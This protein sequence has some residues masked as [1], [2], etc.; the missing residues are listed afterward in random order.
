MLP[1]VTKAIT[2]HSEDEGA[3]VRV[4]F[5]FDTYTTLLAF[6]LVEE[7]QGVMSPS[8]A[9]SKLAELHR[10]NLIQGWFFAVPGL[11]PGLSY[12]NYRQQLKRIDQQVVRGEAFPLPVEETSQETRRALFGFIGII[13]LCFVALFIWRWVDPDGLA[14]LAQHLKER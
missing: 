2:V 4:S 14:R 6:V 9:R 1:H 7:H 13:V 8:R 12:W 3:A 10:Q 5:V 11:F